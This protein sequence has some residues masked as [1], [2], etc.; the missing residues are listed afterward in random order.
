MTTG[1]VITIFVLIVLLFVAD[2]LWLHWNLP[3]E[4]GKRFVGFVEYLSFWR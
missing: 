4:V 2:A 1:N 3:V